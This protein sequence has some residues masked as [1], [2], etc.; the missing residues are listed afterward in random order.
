MSLGSM[1]VDLM[2]KKLDCM[3]THTSRVMSQIGPFRFILSGLTFKQIILGQFIFPF[4]IRSLKN[5]LK[6]LNLFQFSNMLYEW[7]K[8]RISLIPR[9]N[10]PS[11]AV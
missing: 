7:N 8:T 11:V 9:V 3:H 6:I 1:R 2:D 5:G 4:L 10:S